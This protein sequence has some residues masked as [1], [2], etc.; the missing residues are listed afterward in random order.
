MNCE[1]WKTYSAADHKELV[2]LSSGIDQDNGGGLWIGVE[3][4]VAHLSPG[5]VW[6]FQDTLGRSVDVLQNDGSSGVWLGTHFDG[7]LHQDRGGVQT[8][9]TSENSPLPTNTVS[10]LELAPDGSLWVGSAAIGSAGELDSPVLSR[11]DANGQWTSYLPQSSGLPDSEIT[12]LA[13]NNDGGVW[14]GTKKGL[15]HLSRKN[16][17]EV[18]TTANSGLPS[19]EVTALYDAGADG[20][21]LG[22]LS[23]DTDPVTGFKK[24]GGLA[25]LGL[26]GVW[27]VYTTTNSGLPDNTVKAVL[28]T[29]TGD[30]WVGTPSSSGLAR[31]V[32]P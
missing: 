24:G 12:T 22:T 5:D 28:V 7:L 9:F 23:N 21:W 25:H 16:I 20:L 6:S 11:L 13:T 30:V 27:T 4:G 10:A 8:A 26:N 3:I 19:D 32:R 18:Y 1:I 2:Y 15:A 14:I 29:E 17:W 31:F